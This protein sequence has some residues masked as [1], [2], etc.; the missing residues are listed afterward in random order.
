[1]LLQTQTKHKTAK[2]MKGRQNKHK[3][4]LMQWSYSKPCLTKYKTT[5]SSTVLEYCP[6]EVPAFWRNERRASM[7]K[8]NRWTVKEGMFCGYLYRHR[9]LHFLSFILFF[10][11]V[12]PFLFHLLCLLKLQVSPQNV[13]GA[14]SSGERES[15]KERDAHFSVV[16][17]CLWSLFSLCCS[18]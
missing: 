14:L 18:W 12:P 10:L 15:E 5:H 6:K 16:Q 1:M 3:N 13:A 7:Q 17:C 11:F 8:T 2:T 9:R 4:R